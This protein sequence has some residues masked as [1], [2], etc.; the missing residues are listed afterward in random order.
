MEKKVGIIIL[1]IGLGLLAVSLLADTMGIGQ[2]IGFG[3]YQT[4]GTAAGVVI[5]AV[6]LF[7]TL[8]GKPSQPSP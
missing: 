7:L 3:R 4:T 5:T 6:G 8:K 1:V 2:Y